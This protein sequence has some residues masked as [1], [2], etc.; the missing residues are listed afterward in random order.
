[1]SAGWSRSVSINRDMAVKRFN[2]RS[3]AYHGS[4]CHGD[5]QHFPRFQ[6]APLFFFPVWCLATHTRRG[7]RVEEERVG[8]GA[9]AHPRRSLRDDGQIFTHMSVCGGWRPCYFEFPFRGPTK[10]CPK[11]NARK[12]Q[13][14]MRC[15]KWRRRRQQQKEVQNFCLC[16]S[17]KALI[18]S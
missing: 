14:L 15:V 6:P 18:S 3:S 10:P 13:E 11:S 7:E 4:C 1:M 17:L 2:T 5:V 9:H 12:T 16:S 8:V